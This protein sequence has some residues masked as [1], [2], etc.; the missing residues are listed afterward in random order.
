[1]KNEECF[2][3]IRDN[4]FGVTW[5]IKCGRLMTKPC[6]RKITKVDAEKH[7]ILFIE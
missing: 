7:N 6:D 2:H 1:M 3:K 5:C 4:K